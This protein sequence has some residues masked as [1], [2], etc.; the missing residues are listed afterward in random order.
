MQQASTKR[1]LEKLNQPNQQPAAAPAVEMQEL[2]YKELH[3]LFERSITE[4][5]KALPAHVP[6]ERMNRV[7][8]TAVRNNPE[9]LDADE[10][11][12]L[13]A[14]FRA[15]HLG[16]EPGLLGHCFF[17]A[18][19]RQVTL[20]IGYRG[21]IELLWRTGKIAKIEAREI[22]ENDE[23]DAEHGSNEFLKHKKAWRNRGEIIGF[24]AYIKMTSGAQYFEVMSVEE[25]NEIR[26]NYSADYKNKKKYGKEH[27]SIWHKHYAAMGKKTVLHRIKNTLPLSI[28]EM[29]QF[30][31]DN[32]VIKDV[33]AEP[34]RI[35]ITDIANESN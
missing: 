19:N 9:L 14:A 33:D 4:L 23:F 15:A 16:L 5:K 28:E 1:A 11:T 31:A 10:R 34:E 26:D 25:V 35:D 12:L 29:R 2:R 7:I 30:E 6:A 32:A 21:Y 3:R 13:G 8:M 27:Q 17:V 24:Y 18:Y 20:Q 22:Y